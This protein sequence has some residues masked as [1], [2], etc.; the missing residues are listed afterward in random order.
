MA[1]QIEGVYE[2]VLACAKKEFLE[3]GYKDASLRV[4]AQAAGTSTGSIYT[5]FK[6]KAGL[7]DA[8]VGPAADQLKDMFVEIQENFHSLDDST[9]EAE[10][11][12]YTSRHQMEMLEYIYDHFDEFRLLLDC[13][14]GTRFSSFVDEL[15]D[16]E[17]EYTYKYMEV[18]NC[19]S[20]KSGVVTEDFIHIIVTAY[21]NGMF[22]VVRHN[23]SRDDARKFIRLL[24][25]YHM[26]GFSTVFNPEIS[27]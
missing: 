25:R 1:K 26:Q 7:F 14:D 24:N 12:E 16:I 18:I 13:S 9:Q 10:M 15:V 3:K 20:V 2:A 21:F 19:E 8:I 23:M 6:D 27:E 5:R 17:V 22:E 11:G 4:I